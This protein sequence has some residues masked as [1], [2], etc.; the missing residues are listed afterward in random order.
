MALTLLV[1]ALVALMAYAFTRPE[2]VEVPKVTG[3]SLEKARDRLDRVGFDNVDVERERSSAAVDQ[4]LRQTPDP[5]EEAAKEDPI[6]L[7]VSG[8]PGN[9]RVPSVRNTQF[10][11]ALRELRRAGLKVTADQQP[12]S[13]IREG[14]AIGTSPKEGAQVDRGSRVRLFVSSGPAKVSVPDVV[15]LTREA[16]ETR[17]TREGLDV[18]AVVRQQSDKPEEEVI[19]QT[20]A[21][22]T[23]VD[24]GDGVT[25]TISTGTEKIPVP[26]VVGLSVEDA[27]AM[28]QRDGLGAAVRR[29]STDNEEEEDQVLDQRP[30]AGVEVDR[31]RSVIIFVGR[32]EAPPEEPTPPVTPPPP[33]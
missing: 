10:R 1:L 2:Q 14:F 13:S 9:V 8:G 5:G 27:R 31:G 3:L 6:E 23:N 21:P 20:P 25:I 16:A 7:V 32:F 4:V 30:G 15:G 19:A 29:R 33:P 28:L 11:L 17:I 24:A 26:N 18:A 12:S 22:G